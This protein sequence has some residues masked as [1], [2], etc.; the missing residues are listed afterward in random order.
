MLLA[1]EEA[2]EKAHLLSVNREARPSRQTSCSDPASQSP[3]SPISR[4]TVTSAGSDELDLKDGRAPLNCPWSS[5]GENAFAL[6]W[7]CLRH[8]VEARA[9]R[10]R[11]QRER[12]RAESVQYELQLRNRYT[13]DLERRLE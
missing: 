3:V 11:L 6:R 1:Q 13:S 4:K 5:E 2:L 7:R 12:H 8:A 10:W 9:L